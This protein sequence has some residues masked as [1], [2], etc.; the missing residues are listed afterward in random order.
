MTVINAT[1]REAGMTLVE[2]VVVLMVLAVLSG[3]AVPRLFAVSVEAEAA[4]IVT[5]VNRIFDAVERYAA[6]HGKLPEDVYSGVLPPELDGY[7]SEQ[8]FS[9][10]TSL[11]GKLDWNGPGTT[12]PVYGIDVRVSDW[13]NQAASKLY[14]TLEE[15]AD[16]GD[17]DTGWITADKRRVYFR[18]ARR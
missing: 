16:D 1:R 12:A 15:Q 13:G 9:G 18:L 4:A 3:I 7:L 11:G 6:E 5:N 17:R 8:A 2:I 10:A 14:D